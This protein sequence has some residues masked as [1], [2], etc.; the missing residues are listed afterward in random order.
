MCTGLSAGAFELVR[1]NELPDF[2][3]M[4]KSCKNVAPT[5]N[6]INEK[7]ENI[8]TRQEQRLSTLEDKVASIS[9]SNKENIGQQI[10]KV[11]YELTQN[12]KNDINKMVDDRCRENADRDRRKLNVV[13]FNLV[14]GRSDIGLE[15]KDFD[16]QSITHIA[17]KLGIDNLQIEAIYRLG[18]RTVRASAANNNKPRPLKIVL[19]DKKQRK[20]LL[21]RAKTIK[22]K[23]DTNHKEVIIVRDLTIQQRMERKGNKPNLVPLDTETNHT[24]GSEPMEAADTLNKTVIDKYINENYMDRTSNTTLHYNNGAPEV[25]EPQP[26]SPDISRV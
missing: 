2:R 21:D 16:T 18:K 7:L 14:E 26:T 25:S 4:C 10:E 22:E 5:L 23:L 17:N 15:N 8:N 3:W 11:R 20:D 12:V 13:V 1:N 24:D 9:R 19:K 6:E